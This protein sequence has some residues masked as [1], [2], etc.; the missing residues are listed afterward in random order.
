MRISASDGTTEL[1]DVVTIRELVQELRCMA[2]LARERAR[3]LLGGAVSGLSTDVLA[4]LR[5][6]APGEVD[7]LLG[8]Q[9]DEDPGHRD[10]R[11]WVSG[12][13]ATR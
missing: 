2:Q 3:E 4:R 13:G 12:Q 7:A 10:G 9:S 6:R 1:A 5:E 8:A 11:P